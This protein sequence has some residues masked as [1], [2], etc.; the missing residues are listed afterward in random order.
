MTDRRRAHMAADT[1]AA[2]IFALRRAM[3]LMLFSFVVLGVG[4]L[5]T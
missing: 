2:M 5:I 4:L 3:G 1:E